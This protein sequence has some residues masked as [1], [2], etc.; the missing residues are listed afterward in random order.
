MSIG[1]IVVLSV[2][3]GLLLSRR[4]GGRRKQAG[5]AE[6]VDISAPYMDAKAELDHKGTERF[7]TFIAELPDREVQ[8]VHG[9]SREPDVLD[10]TPRLE[11]DGGF[12]GHE[13]GY[14]E[15]DYSQRSFSFSSDR[16]V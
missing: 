16:E 9:K 1:A 14:L 6:M 2:V 11:L 5:N 10:S 4:R 7:R 3:L 15:A 12:N 13:A 8:E